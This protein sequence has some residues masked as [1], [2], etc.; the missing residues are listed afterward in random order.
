MSPFT[1][2]SASMLSTSSLP[3]RSLDAL[4]PPPSFLPN[5]SDRLLCELLTGQ[6]VQS[7]IKQ[8]FSDVIA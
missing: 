7:L 3:T 8:G 2:V 1:P 6:Q 5:P 4:A